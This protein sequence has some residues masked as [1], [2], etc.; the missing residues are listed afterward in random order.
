MISIRRFEANE[1]SAYRD[2]RLGALAESPDAFGSKLEYEQHRTDAEWADR[3]ALAADTEDD[4]PLVAESD[5]R[6][7]GLA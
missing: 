3:L 6:P 4:R 1:W 7:V 5:G 2:L